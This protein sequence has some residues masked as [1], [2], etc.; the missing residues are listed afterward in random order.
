MIPALASVL[1]FLSAMA[2][3]GRVDGWTGD[4]DH[5]LAADTRTA[6]AILDWQA[7]R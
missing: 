7:G 3:Q 4:L 1:V 5:W 2:R 6:Q